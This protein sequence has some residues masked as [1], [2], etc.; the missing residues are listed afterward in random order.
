MTDTTTDYMLE[1]NPLATIADMDTLATW[2]DDKKN[3]F[4]KV[5]ED[6]VLTARYI[7]RKTAKLVQERAMSRKYISYKHL[8]ELDKLESY[9]DMTKVSRSKEDLKSIAD[10][11]AN[12]I[13]KELP[14]LKKAVQWIDPDTAKMI[15]RKEKLLKK[16]NELRDQL[17]EVCETIDM[18]DLDQKM[19]IGEFRKLVADREKQRKSLLRKLEDVGAEG[20]KLEDII[21]KKLYAGLPGLSDAVVKTI[22]DHWERCTALDAMNRRVMETVKFGDSEAAMSIL[23]KFEEDEVKVS[24]ELKTRIKD[25]V[26]ILKASAKGGTKALKGGKKKSSKKAKAK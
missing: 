4:V 7:L 22:K 3:D 16:A 13:L 23:R 25:A 2:S 12:L 1:G 17:D 11:R 24:D 21:A 15:D 26:E 18:A 10:E 5:F 19:S 9:V 6:R 14:P 8:R 20:T